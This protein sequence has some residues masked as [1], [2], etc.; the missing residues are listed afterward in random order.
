MMPV[1]RSHLALLLGLALEGRGIAWMP[2]SVVRGEIE[3]KRLVEAGGK[4]W[5]IPMEIRLFRPRSKLNP[6][7]ETFWSY[8]SPVAPSSDWL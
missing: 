5:S 8:V 2:A 1:A 4:Q 7:A 6:A 3:R